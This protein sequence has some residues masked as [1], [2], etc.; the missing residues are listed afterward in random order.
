MRTPLPRPLPPGPPPVVI[1]DLHKAYRRGAT[2]TPTLC[3]VELTVA[4]G[5]CVFLVGPSGCGKSTLLSIL[6]CILTPDRGTVQV[7]G[8]DLSRL[9]EISRSALR[10]NHIGFVFQRFQ[11]I[12][13]LSAIENVC[14]PLILRGES[15]RVAR[16]RA[17]RLLADVGLSDKAGSNPAELST[18]QCQR[19]ALARALVGDPELILADEPTAALDAT[20][21]QEV[22]QLLRTL[23]TGEGKTAVVVTHDPRILDFADRVL[24][25]DNGRIS[26]NDAST[27]AS[28]AGGWR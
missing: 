22:M 3:G 5:E 6:G 26:E 23:T 12:R 18:G 24:H 16:Q 20:A 21:G 27:L 7:L 2:S 4:A 11:L 9:D 19:V 28:A 8:H 10:R 17:S 15:Q 1:H 14:V 25:L 13:G